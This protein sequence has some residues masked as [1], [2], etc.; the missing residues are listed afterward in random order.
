MKTRRI[1][2]A[3][4]LACLLA[5]A[6][7]AAA[8]AE[9]VAPPSSSA[10]GDGFVAAA[11]NDGCTSRNVIEFSKRDRA[12]HFG[13]ISCRVPTRIGCKATLAEVGAGTISEI[14][15]QGGNRCSMASRFGASE[16]YTAGTVLRESFTYRLRLT[17]H[18]DRWAGINDF[19]PRRA[20]QRRVLI[21]SDSHSTVAPN[22]DAVRHG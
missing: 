14:S 7:P 2:R 12:R 20:K 10:S 8:A 11:Q 18:R 9:P 21:C 6:L 17:R 1:G 15:S 22:R 4:L 3:A 5:T 19:C 16:R 13:E